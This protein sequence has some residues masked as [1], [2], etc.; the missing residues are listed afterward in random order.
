MTRKSQETVAY[1]REYNNWF[2]DQSSLSI[3][4][5]LHEK[6]KILRKAY[7]EHTKRN[8]CLGDLVELLIEGDEIVTNL[9]KSI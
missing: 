5:S 6:L 1:V 2:S 4:K 3:N 8:I 9:Y 7:R